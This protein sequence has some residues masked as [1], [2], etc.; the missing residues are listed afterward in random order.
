MATVTTQSALQAATMI[1]TLYMSFELGETT[2]KLAFTTG[3]AQRPR[4]RVSKARDLEQVAAEIAA[5]KRRFGLPADAPVVSCYEAGR[6][7]AWLHRALGARG[8]SNRVV[9]AASIEVNRRARR[10]KADRLDAEKLVLMLVR[11]EQGDRRTWRVVHVLED[12]DEDARQLQRELRA[13][14]DDRTRLTNR[15]GSLLATQGLTLR[16]TGDV[17]AALRALRRWDGTPLPPALLA[18]L[19]REWATAEALRARIAALKQLRHREL[20]DGPD[21]ASAQMRQLVQLRG[22]GDAFAT[23]LVREAFGPRRFRNGREVGALAGLVPTPYQSGTT[24]HEQGISKAGNRY[25]RHMAVELAWFWLRY[26]PQHE[27]SQWYRRRFAG[28]GKAAER[29]GI[30]AVAR[31]V[32][33]AL[34]RY[35]RDGVLPAGAVLKPEL[36]ARRAA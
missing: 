32:L 23:T 10:A 11:Y 3:L 20:T 27:L 6:D 25:L 16:L 34:W 35:L 5:A 36:A 7:G 8:I 18:R 13:A 1:G 31:K 14:T 12:G 30:V 9:D 19:E 15:I 26:Q 28:R 4:V 24:H 29:V 33:V 2:W 22:I 21:A 17:P